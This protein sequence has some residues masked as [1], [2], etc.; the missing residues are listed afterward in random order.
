[1]RAI[2]WVDLDPLIRGEKRHGIVP[3]AGQACLRG[4]LGKR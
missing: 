1:M 3:E 4:G 2:K